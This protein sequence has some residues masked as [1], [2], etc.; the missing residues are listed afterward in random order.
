MS[1]VIGL[2]D[3]GITAIAYDNENKNREDMYHDH[4]SHKDVNETNLL[5]NYKLITN[6]NANNK[7]KIR[8]FKNYVGKRVFSGL[9]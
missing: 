2:S 1:K 4:G 9:H 5:D 3:I 7:E 8:I 6:T